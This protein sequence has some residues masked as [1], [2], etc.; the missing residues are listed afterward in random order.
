MDQAVHLQI[1]VYPQSVERGGIKAGQEHIDHDKQIDF[2]IFYPH[3]QV[4]I[5]VLELIGRRIKICTECRIVILDCAIQ[6]IT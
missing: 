1:L 5:I 2:P 3:G 6:K 4:F